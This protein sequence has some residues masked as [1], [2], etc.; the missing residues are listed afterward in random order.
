MLNPGELNARIEIC[1]TKMAKTP[2][3]AQTPV[4]TPVLECYAKIKTVRGMTLIAN[5]VTFDKAYVKFTIRKP[6]ETEI[7]TKHVIKYRHNRY[8]I[9]YVDDVDLRGEILEI[10]AL[11]VKL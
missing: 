10:Q 8:R 2:D 9:E 3:G 5:Q 4:D 11:E 1:K 7:T 6:A